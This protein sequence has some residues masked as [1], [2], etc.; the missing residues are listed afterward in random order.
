MSPTAADCCVART[1]L[2]PTEVSRGSEVGE[3]PIVDCPQHDGESVN[4]GKQCPA[5][6]P[7]T[8][9]ILHIEIQTHQNTC[10]QIVINSIWSSVKHQTIIFWV[11]WKQLAKFFKTTSSIF[12]NMKWKSLNRFMICAQRRLSLLRCKVFGRFAVDVYRWAFVWFWICGNIVRECSSELTAHNIEC[13][14]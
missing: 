4:R 14:R 5:F 11:G 10:Y 6:V 2:M 7:R 13:N 12:V 3:R 1:G 9:S 8:V